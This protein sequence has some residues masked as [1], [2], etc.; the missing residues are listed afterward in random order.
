M[1]SPATTPRMPSDLPRESSKRAINCAA[2]GPV[3]ITTNALL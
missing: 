3:R 2:P 1:S